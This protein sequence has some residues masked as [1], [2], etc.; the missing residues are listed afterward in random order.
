MSPAANLPTIVASKSS[1]LSGKDPSLMIETVEMKNSSEPALP[2]VANLEKLGIAVTLGNSITPPVSSDTTTT[3][4]A[5]VYGNGFSLEN[6]QSLLLS[7]MLDVVPKIKNVK[8]YA[9]ITE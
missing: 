3:Q 6:R 1:S 7:F 8:K 5:V 4:D 9:A 2:D